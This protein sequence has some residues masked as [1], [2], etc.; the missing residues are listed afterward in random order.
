MII[1]INDYKG[2]SSGKLEHIMLGTVSKGRISGYHCDKDYIDTNAVVEGRHYPKTKRI[3]TCN[4]YHKVFEGIVKIK[5]STTRII[6]AGN[7]GKSSFFS[8][9][10]SRQDVVDC[11][12]RIQSNG[13][14]IKQYKKITGNN[15]I[16]MDP[17]TGLIIVDNSASSYPLIRL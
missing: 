8:Y 15:N 10:W 9:E 14:T 17:K 2:I 11:I 16:C 5:T 7:N 1:G 12:S 6:K 3:V 13:K 4:R